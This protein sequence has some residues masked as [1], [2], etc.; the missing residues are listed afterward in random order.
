MKTI[1]LRLNEFGEKMIASVMKASGYKTKSKALEYI[2]I[3]HD[4]LTD[5]NFELREEN[6][7]LKSVLKFHGIEV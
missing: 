1:T 4:V 3:S 5:K 7:Y 2:V 6:Q